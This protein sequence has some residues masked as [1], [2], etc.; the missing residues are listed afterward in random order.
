MKEKGKG[1]I[2]FLKSV[3]QKAE[4][5]KAAAAAAGE[6]TWSMRVLTGADVNDVTLRGTKR[7]DGRGL[8]EGRN[9]K[10][11]GQ[12]PKGAKAAVAPRPDVLTGAGER[13]G[14]APATPRRAERGA[15]VVNERSR[16]GC[17]RS[18][19]SGACRRC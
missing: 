11:G 16:Q 7:D 5:E 6:E 18:C 13:I 19:G 2:D 9:L 17:G 1:F 15:G 14:P 12:E 10:S 3:Q 4:E 8:V